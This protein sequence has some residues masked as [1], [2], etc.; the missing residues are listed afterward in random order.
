VSQVPNY[1][2]AVVRLEKVSGYLLSL[3]HSDG[4]AKAE[5]FLRFGFSPEGPQAL[6][7]ALL[8]HCAE[9]DVVKEKRT[10]FGVQYVVEGPLVSPD[11]RNPM[12]RSVWVIEHGRRSPRLVT[13]YPL[14]PPRHVV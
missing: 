14:P 5:F 9:N 6:A 8:R 10:P 2:T 7:E 3:S 13:A 12:L 4:R 1:R 11:G